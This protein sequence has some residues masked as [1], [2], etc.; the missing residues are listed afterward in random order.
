MVR[1]LRFVLLASVLASAPGLFAQQNE[2]PLD[3]DVYY[4]I[5]RNGS[6]RGSTMHTGL[7][8][9]LQGRAETAQVR[10]WSVDS[11]KQYYW[12]LDKLLKSHLVEVREGDFHATVDALLDFQAGQ[13]LRESVGEKDARDLSHNG[14]GFWIT[15]DI[16]PTLSFQTAFRENQAFLPEYLRQYAQAQGIMP[17]QGRVKSFNTRGLDFAWATADLSWSPRPWLNAQIGQG[18]HFVGNGYRSMLLSDNT[19][20][21]PF[22]KLSALT[23]NKRF[24]YTIIHA[25]LQMLGDANRLPTSDAAESLFYWKRASFHHLSMNLGPVQLGLFEA[26]LW[27]NVDT[28]GG[29]RSYDAME[30]NPLIGLNAI[31]HGFHGPNKQLVGLDLKW[32]LMDRLF[33]YG[34]YALDD[35]DNDRNAWQVGAQWWHRVLRHEVHLLL[36]YNSV[37]PFAYTTNDARMNY[38]HDG[39]PLAGPLG[40]GYNEAV[41]IVD[42]DLGKRFWAKVQVSLADLR[43]DTA[44]TSR[45]GGSIFQN[46]LPGTGSTQ[47]VA[48]QRTWID[49]NLAYRMNPHTN[50]Q[51]FLGW[52]WRSVTP[53]GVGLLPA[54]ILSAGI[55]TGLFNRYYDL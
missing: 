40:T 14:R 8:P 20:T 25:K 27:N 50:L 55:R 21:Y 16:G 4:G 42:V 34:Q 43:L 10:G 22:V 41:G 35:P 28:I 39:Q 32:R 12:L 5:D 26:T 51:I 18:R 19:S 52:S 24:Q 30:L 46:D 53:E 37:A 17:G 11:T 48:Q 49:V 3:R 13:D 33:L 44:A 2:I 38:V 1:R 36:E 23:N 15:A 45:S 9:I 54:N 29:V 6:L 7:R 31:V 47:T